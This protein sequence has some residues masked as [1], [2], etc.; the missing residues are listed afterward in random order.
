MPTPEQFWRW[1]RQ[2]RMHIGM[3]RIA[4]TDKVPFVVRAVILKLDD[5]VD[6]IG[7]L[8][9]HEAVL[10]LQVRNFPNAYPSPLLVEVWRPELHL[11]ILSE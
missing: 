8:P 11:R 7:F 1:F 9:T 10:P 5:V 6:N 4:E 3:T 2:P